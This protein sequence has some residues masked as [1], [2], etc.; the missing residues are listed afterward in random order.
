[1][2]SVRVDNFLVFLEEWFKGPCR[3]SLVSKREFGLLV[4][5]LSSNVGF[6]RESMVFE[7]FKLIYWPLLRKKFYESNVFM[8]IGYWETGD[9]EPL[10]DNM[11]YDRIVYDFDSEENPQFAVETAREFVALIEERY[12]ANAV[13]V[14][15]GF[16]GAHVYISLKNPVRWEDYQ[17]LWKALLKLLPEEK[18]Q[19]CDLNML[20]WNRL[21]RIPMTV[22]YKN[23]E[24]RWA[25]IIQ[26][27]VH[28]WLDFKWSLV[29]PLDPASLPIAKIKVAIPTLQKHY[30]EP[31][32]VATPVAGDDRAPSKAGKSR[33]YDWVEK[34]IERGLSD[35]RKRFILY[36]LSAYLVNV[37]GLSEEEALQV[38][39]E[40]LENSCRNHGRCDKV[41]E[42]FICGDLRRVRSKGLRPMSLEKLREKDPELYSI[43]EKAIS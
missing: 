13:V 7:G 14:K 11:Y 25:W 30:I 19:L 31:V 3:V 38:V 16:K 28:G 23:G 9:L 8:S 24:R 37:K 22:N 18:R 1:V 10:L 33:R 36:V 34:I 39:Q 42:S 17:V 2:F 5:D 32:E 26:P 41:Y 12:G 4:G 43:V 6:K 15:S 35:G 40:F 21:A 20:Q 27:K 29:E